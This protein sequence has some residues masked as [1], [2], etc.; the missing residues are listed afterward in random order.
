MSHRRGPPK[1]LFNAPAALNG[2]G[3]AA[4]PRPKLPKPPPLFTPPVNGLGLFVCPNPPPPNGAL[5]CENWHELPFRQ[6]PLAKNLHGGLFPP[7]LKVLVSSLPEDMPKGDMLLLL[8]PPLPA[9]N[10]WENLQRSP[11]LQEP[12]AKNLHGSFAVS[13]PPTLCPKPCPP[14]LLIL[15][16]DGP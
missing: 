16:G 14:L 4:A 13:P 10:S 6:L 9:P 12:L 3:L 1:G 2:E 5:L 7:L 15:N 8:P 11:K